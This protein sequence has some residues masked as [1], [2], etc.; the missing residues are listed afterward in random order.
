MPELS[1]MDTDTLRK[2]AAASLARVRRSAAAGLATQAE[3]AEMAFLRAHEILLDRA[4]Q[5]AR[6]PLGEPARANAEERPRSSRVRMP[7]TPPDLDRQDEISRWEA[8]AMRDM[9]AIVQEYLE[10]HRPPYDAIFLDELERW[11]QRLNRRAGEVERAAARNDEATGWWLK[12]VAGE[13]A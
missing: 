10:T 4:L 7:A 11:A 13:V 6:G 12:A 2:Y 1:S 5:A 3:R 8:Q 9:A